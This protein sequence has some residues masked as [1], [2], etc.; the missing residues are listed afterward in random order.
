MNINE[1][2]INDR[3]AKFL[4]CIRTDECNFHEDW[5]LLMRACKKFD[6]LNETEPDLYNDEY[7][8]L[9]EML[10]HYVTLYDILPVFQWLNECIEWYN[11]Y[12]CNI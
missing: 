6:C 5:N 7:V 2:Y 10:D 9:C 8:E 4:G 11:A 3:I 1:E 12:H